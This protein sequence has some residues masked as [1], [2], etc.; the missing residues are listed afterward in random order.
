MDRRQFVAF[1][2][3]AAAVSSLSVPFAAR[4]QQKIPRVGVLLVSGPE[5]MGPF[6]EALRALGYVE[7]NTIQI[8]VRSA[9]GKIDRLPE[10]AAELVRGK[11]DVI[12]A[13]LTPAVTAAKNATRD[14]PIV[15]APA[16]DPVGTGLVASL[17]RPGGNITGLS[18][19]GAELGSKGLELVRE[20]LP[21]A[22]RVAVLG[23]ANDPFS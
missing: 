10:L 13:S 21:T 2:G 4:A 8:E 15:M 19:T 9:E 12:V 23:Y 20:V 5:N 22:R 3:G 6:R 18:G 7:G 14:I 16:G 17:A 1:V 11:V